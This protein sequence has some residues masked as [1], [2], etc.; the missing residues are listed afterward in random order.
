MLTKKIYILITLL[1]VNFTVIDKS[2]GHQRIDHTDEPASSSLTLTLTELSDNQGHVYLGAVIKAKELAPYL[3]ELKELLG[4]QFKQYRKMQA[5]RDHQLFHMTL[6]SPN[7]YK[8]ADKT[9]IKKLLDTNSNDKNPSQLTV[10]LL[11]LGTIKHDTKETFFVVTQSDDGQL[12]RQRFL[13]KNKDFHVT[14]GFSPDDI[15]GVKK[16]SSTLIK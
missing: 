3:T 11:G 5:A 14:L 4:N 9:L 12:I 10:T 7:E 2:D 13:L 8:A 15:Y 6:L 1:L 16:D